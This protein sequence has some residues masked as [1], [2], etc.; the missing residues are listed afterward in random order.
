[1][2]AADDGSDLCDVVD[3][4]IVGAGLSGLTT[5]VRVAQGGMTVLVLEQGEGRYPCN[6][7]SSGGILHVA[8]QDV[9]SPPD[10]L[11]ATMH[12]AMGPDANEELIDG[13]AY[14]A[15]A[16][17]AWLER[18]GARF[19]SASA[20]PWHRWTL[21]PPRPLRPGLDFPGS[22]P[23]R[24]LGSLETL[25]DGLGGRLLR[26]RRVAAIDRQRA[27]FDILAETAS[28][29]EI[30]RSRTVVFADGG[31]QGDAT[32]VAEH[33]TA[34]PDR[35][36]QRGAGTG[37]GSAV[38][39]ARGRGCGT[40]RMDRF[41]G[42]L[43][44]RDALTNKGLWPYPQLDLIA[45]AGIVV[46]ASGRRFCEEWRGGVYIANEIAKRPDPAG[47]Y[48]IIDTRI[49]EEQGRQSL[50]PVVPHLEESGGTVL[51]ATTIPELA[52]LAGI[53]PGVLVA[54]VRAFNE[55]KAETRQRP[56]LKAI[57]VAPFLAVPLSVGITNTMGGI[58]VDARARALSAEGNP[59][60]G[61]YA[62][63][64]SAGGLEG[65]E[66]VGYVGGLMRAVT[67]GLAAGEDI[68]GGRGAQLAAPT[69]TRRSS[70]YPVLNALARH[71]GSA[72]IACG[73]LCGL[74]VGVSLWPL[75]S[76][77]DLIPCL[78]ATLLAGGV[79]KAF[80]ELSAIVLDLLV[81]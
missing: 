19:V 6:S 26:G 11:S 62:V 33:I 59:V 23:D 61:I 24:L 34:C 57:E 43:L 75:S 9:Q 52:G 48:A 7:R 13:I 14:G 18:S 60:P 64:A 32:L 2:I 16:A 70:P 50:Y 15:A 68:C 69:A 77:L 79:A 63:G 76:P 49:W 35:I 81:R 80:A 12:R 27:G 53:D 71:G 30:Y 74:A 25:L 58:R 47:A 66:N 72:A 55:G 44:S 56:S 21:A 37:R 36:V 39:L 20:V 5:A 38:R 4:V 17:L 22:G 3:V 65:G 28:G 45:S 73:V 51:R 10:L 42:H 1:M 41:Y 46:E 31:F 67:S 40:T 8:Y 78:V 54:T 29:Q